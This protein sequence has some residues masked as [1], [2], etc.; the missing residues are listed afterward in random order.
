MRDL[1]VTLGPSLLADLAPALQVLFEASRWYCGE[2]HEVGKAAL[3]DALADGRRGPLRPVL[4]RFLRTLMQQPVALQEI[5]TAFERRFSALLAERD[6]A[7]IGVRATAA[8]ADAKPAWPTS[9]CHSVDVQVAASDLQALAAGD[10]LAVIGDVHPG[11]NPLL[12]GLF[13]HRAPDPAAMLRRWSDAL[14]PIQGWLLPP[15]APGLGVDARGIPI[16][17]ET[18]AHIVAVPDAR[19]QFP[20]E[21]WLAD[22]L[23]IDGDDIVHAPSG[24]R[25]PLLETVGMAIF[26]AGV[27]AFE[28]LPEHEHAP[29]L[30]VGRVVL[31]RETWSIPASEIPQRAED[32]PAFARDREMPRRVFAKS[33]LERKPMFLDVESPVLAR[34]LVRH[35]R[36]AAARYPT[37]RMRFSEMLPAPEDC[38]LAD[39]HG[40]RYV[41]ELRIVAVDETRR[42]AYAEPTGSTRRAARSSSPSGLASRHIKWPGR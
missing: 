9:V 15:Y 7:T 36:Q 28:L 29:R 3:A 41:S 11:A 23:T 26:V 33:P 1:D 14:G 18:A 38:W 24:R 13:G 20:R 27:R 2:V 5:V 17:P 40:E 32:I 16:T 8:F 37:A 25:V 34:I 10:Y 35:A 6:A 12:Q 22:E 21:T 19:A 42:A 30:V 4:S 39:A 31:R